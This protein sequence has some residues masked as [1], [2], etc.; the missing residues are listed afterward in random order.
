MES[1]FVELSKYCTTKI[2]V[3]NCNCNFDKKAF[4]YIT[5]DGKSTNQG[6][7]NQ[8]SGMD[9]WIFI[10][11]TVVGVILLVPF[12]GSRNRQRRCIQRIK[13][14]RWDVILEGENNEGRSSLQNRQQNE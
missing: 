10:W 1:F 6:T 13:Q 4:S 2:W 9:A 5:M 8:G 3:L 7:T 14:R 12:C 11:L